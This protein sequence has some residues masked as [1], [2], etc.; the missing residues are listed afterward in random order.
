[1]KKLRR[2]KKGLAILLT[3]AMVVG[4]MLGVDIMQVSAATQEEEFR[5][6][7]N[8]TFS[9]EEMADNDEDIV[10]IKSDGLVQLEL[11]VITNVSVKRF[12]GLNI[13]EIPQTFR[14]RIDYVNI[15]PV[16]SSDNKTQ[17]VKLYIKNN[18]E[19]EILPLTS[20]FT[21]DGFQVCIKQ[22]L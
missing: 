2:L 16:M 6:T 19:I 3:A 9:E 12:I 10:I 13:A 8:V 14:P 1:M 11:S 5:I 15:M 21:T 20:A 17:M 4:L 7:E 22:V 18:G